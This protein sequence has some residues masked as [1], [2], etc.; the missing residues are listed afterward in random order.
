MRHRVYG[1]HLGRDKN[2]RTALFKSL[3]RNLL[4]SESI[5]TTEMKAKS[6]KGLVDKIITQAKTGNNKKLVSQFLIDKPV[7]DKLFTDIAPRF[8]K[9][10]SGFTTIVKTG[11][12]K[13]DGA[14]IVQM[15]LI[16]KGD[17]KTKETKKSVKVITAADEQIE[18]N[19][20]DPKPKTPVKAVKKTPKKE[21]K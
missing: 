21:A 5:E 3:V 4:I 13:G 10:T 7:L 9:R 17:K 16:E 11:V 2:Q 1:K 19:P 12:R 14:R 8:E 18:V 20:E 6:I 15:S